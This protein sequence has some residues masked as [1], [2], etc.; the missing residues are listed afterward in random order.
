MITAT[1][2]HQRRNVMKRIIIATATL[3]FSALPALAGEGTGSSTMELN[4]QGQKDECLLVAKNCGDQVDTIQERI[5]R[6]NHEIGK[7]NA[8]YTREELRKLGSE[9]QDAEKILEILLTN[10]GS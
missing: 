5:N 2:K 6:L 1:S 3:L 10:S 9:L 7:G 8:V 4:Q